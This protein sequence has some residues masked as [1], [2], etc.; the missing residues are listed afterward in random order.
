MRGV[1]PPVVLEQFDEVRIDTISQNGGD[2]LHY[3][4]LEELDMRDKCSGCVTTCEPCKPDENPNNTCTIPFD[5][6]RERYKDN[7][8]TAKHYEL[9][10]GCTELKHLIWYKNMNAQ[11]GE[12]FRKLWRLGRGDRNDAVRDLNGVIAYCEQ[13]KERIQMYEEM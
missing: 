4:E 2:G 12:A 3:P 7:G 5:E 6:M 13:E 10:E 8:S 9:P 1:I 11:V